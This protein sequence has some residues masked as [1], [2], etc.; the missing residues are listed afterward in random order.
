MD[1][2]R[3][4]WSRFTIPRFFCRNHFSSVPF[5]PPKTGFS[6]LHLKFPKSIL[7]ATSFHLLLLSL[8]FPLPTIHLIDIDL[9][10]FWFYLLWHWNDETS[11]QFF[12]LKELPLLF[13]SSFS[14]TFGLS[15]CAKRHAILRVLPQQVLKYCWV[16]T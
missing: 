10:E 16:A 11:F 6:L 3:I 2:R 7:F 15:R 12:F 4:Y 13:H 5:Y 14:P 1:L 8:H 9:I